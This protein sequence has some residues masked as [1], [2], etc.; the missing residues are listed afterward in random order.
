MEDENCLNLA[1]SLNQWASDE[2]LSEYEEA[3]KKN[4]LMNNL[5]KMLDPDIHTFIDLSMRDVSGGTGS[6]CGLAAMYQALLNTI[7]TK[8][9]LKKYSYDA[10]KAKMAEEML[11]DPK[12]IRKTKDSDLLNDFFLCKIISSQERE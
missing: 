6:L 1:L 8:S 2:E 5:N 11:K 4:A 9:Q 12:S 3:D 7:L 10:M